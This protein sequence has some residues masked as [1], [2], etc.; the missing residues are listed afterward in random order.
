VPETPSELEKQFIE[1]TSRV[2]G[3]RTVLDRT[4]RPV[5]LVEALQLANQPGYIHLARTR[6]T[7]RMPPY[8]DIDVS[9]VWLLAP[10][11]TLDSDIPLHFET[12][13]FPRS[14]CLEGTAL[15]HAFQGY[16][17]PEDAVRDHA[18][19]AQYIAARLGDP[20]VIPHRR[21]GKRRRTKPWRGMSAR[22][23]AEAK[24]GIAPRSSGEQWVR[25]RRGRPGTL[26]MW[27]WDPEAEFFDVVH[28]PDTPDEG[29]GLLR[30][31][32]AR[33]QLR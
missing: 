26:A 22:R 11:H 3:G 16:A 20:V 33:R 25:G 32:A 17:N 21:S 24:R 8:F 30:S 31:S 19:I 10:R 5:T 28:L 15:T 29:I 1:A 4:G 18:L 7:D 2:F 23:R 12:M 6:V 27:T 9:T 14:A 13:L